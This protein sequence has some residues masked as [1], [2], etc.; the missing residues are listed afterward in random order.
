[1]KSAITVSAV[2]EA[3]GGPFVL[4]ES[5]PNAC[6]IAARCGFD[7]IEVFAPHADY[8]RETTFAS[9]L[10]ASGLKFAAAGTGAGWVIHKLMLSHPD[11]LHRQR[12]IDF[13]RSIIDAVSSWGTQV[14][15]GSMQ[16]KAEHA[17]EVP[18][19]LGR[20]QDSLRV[21]AEYASSNGVRLLIEPLN[22]YETNLVTSVETGLQVANKVGSELKLLCDVFHMNIEESSIAKSLEDAGDFVGHVHFA[23]SNR[24]AVGFGHIDY[25]PIIAS[26]QQIEYKGFLSAEVFAKPDSETAAKQTQ[27][28]F[29]SL[30]APEMFGSSGLV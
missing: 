21:L 30:T 4:W 3:R 5:F 13:V 10:N 6:E 29:R 11:P 16:G 2:E 7:G 14:I 22:R 18:D 26:L 28:A 27:L 8:F 17:K 23:D 24:W 19:Y 25:Q 15:I 12:A 1:M 20:L 9:A